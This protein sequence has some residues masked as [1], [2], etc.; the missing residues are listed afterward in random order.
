MA[1]EYSI[2]EE[3]NA[4]TAGH[5]SQYYRVRLDDQMRRQR[6]IDIEARKV[7]LEEQKRRPEPPR[8]D[9]NR[10]SAF[11]G[12]KAPQSASRGE[13]TALR[14]EYAYAPD[15]SET[16]ISLKSSPKAR[17]IFIDFMA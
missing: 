15:T 3:T 7:T 10:K 1:P 9:E 11:S 16:G 6:I 17:G 2:P 13:P 14:S 8:T 12:R 4:R 5:L